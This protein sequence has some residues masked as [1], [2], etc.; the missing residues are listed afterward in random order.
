VENGEQMIS[1]TAT[2]PFVGTQSGESLLNIGR[3][4]EARLIEKHRLLLNY[5]YMVNGVWSAKFSDLLRM[6]RT[7]DSAEYEGKVRR[8]IHF[9]N[10]VYYQLRAMHT[11]E[12]MT[13]KKLR[14]MAYPQGFGGGSASEILLM[15]S[16]HAATMR[17]ILLS[18]KDVLFFGDN[19]N[20][21]EGYVGRL[22]FVGGKFCLN[23]ERVDSV[24]LE[25]NQHCLLFERSAN[26]QP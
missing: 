22:T 24:S 16:E 1:P 4:I 11:Q 2:E 13:L 21:P 9:P 6:T 20:L 19:G 10:P 25:E 18:F 12:P 17:L 15:L 7:V 14:T 3:E 23:R 8:D 26:Q 5:R